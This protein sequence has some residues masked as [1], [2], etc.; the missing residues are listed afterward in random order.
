MSDFWHSGRKRLLSFSLSHTLSRPDPTGL[1]ISAGPSRRHWLK[2]PLPVGANSPPH[3]DQSP[4]QTS[5]DHNHK[6]HP[7]KHRPT[8]GLHKNIPQHHRESYCPTNLSFLPHKSGKPL[9]NYV[10][11]LGLFLNWRRQQ[12][13]ATSVG[14]GHLCK[15]RG[16]LWQPRLGLFCKN[17]GEVYSS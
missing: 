3:H 2:S 10:L 11:E 15:M 13:A 9:N 1:L 6:S 17:G 16:Y 8:A 4:T 5:R 12:Q 7:G 14:A